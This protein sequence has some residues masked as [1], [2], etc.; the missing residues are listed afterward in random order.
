ME[1]HDEVAWLDLS[2]IA[3]DVSFREIC[4]ESISNGVSMPSTCNA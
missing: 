3:A 4:V 2:E 1:K